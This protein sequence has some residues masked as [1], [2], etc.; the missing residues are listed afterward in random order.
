MSVEVDGTTITTFV[1]DSCVIIFTGLEEGMVV[2]LGVRDRK[3][4]KPIFDEI[5]SIADSEG[6]VQFVIPPELTN[7]FD[8]KL[9][10]TVAIYNYGIKVVDESTGEENTVLLGE[11]PQFGETYILKAYLK[12]VEGLVE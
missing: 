4:N 11:N 2:Y 3:T 7:K 12:K 6:E 1:G 9:P 5:K 8:I 10:Q